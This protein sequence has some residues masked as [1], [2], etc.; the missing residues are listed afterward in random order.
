MGIY[1]AF[2]P[3]NK[4]SM[5]VGSS[6]LTLEKLE[7]NHRNYFKFKDGYES[8]FRKALR[9][10]GRDWKF[11]WLLH[12]RDISR[13]QAEIEEGVVIRLLKPRYNKDMFPYE[14]SVKRGRMTQV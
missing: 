10:C 11:R 8:K 12:P 13:L 4:K 14:T 3:S 6:G 2:D 9:D 7:Y 1:E 5:Y